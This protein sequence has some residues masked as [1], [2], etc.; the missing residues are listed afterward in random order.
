VRIERR[1][2]HRRNERLENS[3][4]EINSILRDAEDKIL[5]RKKLKMPKYPIILILGCAR[6]GSTLMM[7]WIAQ[8]GRFAYPSNLLSR[9]Y[10]APYIGAKIQQILTEFDHNNEIFDFN[11]EIPFTSKLGKTKGALDTNE[12]WYFW[13]RFFHYSEIQYLDKEDLK[14]IDSKTFVSELA[15]IEAVFNKPIA[16]KG[17]IVNWN[18][19]Y[20][21]SL[22]DKVLFLYVK[23]N[24]FYNAQSLL[25]ARDNF[26]GTRKAWYSFKPKEYDKL[27]KLDPFGQVAGQVYFTNNAI[28]EGLAQIDNSYW[29]QVSYEEFCM[30][31][32]QV[33]FDILEKLSGQGCEIDKNYT[34]QEF[35]HS[36]N[37]IRLPEDESKKLLNAYKY[38]S[39]TE[40]TI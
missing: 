4:T 18:I 20:I 10:G 14:T 40:L 39:K 3:L 6:S 12:F 38:F 30:N 15:A 27:N 32:K 19:P 25:E 1:K 8:T 34:G 21:F 33:F 16:M 17:M 24:P 23:R 9:F 35:F 7:Q 28:E 13:R 36:T 11:E 31:P 26:Y 5:E 22:L 37:S 29:M 2:E